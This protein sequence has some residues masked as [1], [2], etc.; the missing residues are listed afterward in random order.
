MVVQSDVVDPAWIGR[1]WLHKT[2]L[3]QARADAFRATLAD[4]HAFALDFADMEQ[5]WRGSVRRLYDWLGLPL[6]EALMA[7]MEA[8]MAR[9]RRHIGH[10]YRLAD[11]GLTPEGVTAALAAS[12]PAYRPSS[13]ATDAAVAAS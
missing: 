4:T 5:D 3:R 9:E 12:S 6:G 11:F 13:T 10:R 7:R 2:A 1:E 8:Y